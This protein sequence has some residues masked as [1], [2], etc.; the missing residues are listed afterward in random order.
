MGVT[1]FILSFLLLAAH[2]AFGQQDSLPSSRI[3]T[4]NPHIYQSHD[5]VWTYS[6]ICKTLRT[7]MHTSQP[8]P[9]INDAVRQKLFTVHGNVQYDFIYRSLVDTPFSQKD[10]AQHTVQTTLDFLIKEQY[11]V[12]VTVLSRQSNSPYFADL[13][14]VNAVQPYVLYESTE[15]RAY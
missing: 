13:T 6:G 15:S 12:R 3:L 10:F 5:T 8:L 11:P 9:A 7:T 1:R 4:I 2:Q 14:D